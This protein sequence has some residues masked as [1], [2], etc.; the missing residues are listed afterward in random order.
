MKVTLPSTG[1]PRSA[2]TVTL[3]ALPISDR[4]DVGFGHV[5]DDPHARVIGD[6]VELVPGLH[7]LAIDDLLLDHVAGRRR[8]PIDGPWIGVGLAHLV[9][10][11]LRDAEV[12]QPQHGAFKTL[13]HLGTGSR[14]S[15]RM[16]T[17]RSDCAN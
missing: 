10:A 9:D 2:R 5:G 6:P 7:L 13:V 3:R 14:P 1:A 15:V 8:R 4:P 12:P 17:I 16:A 11:A